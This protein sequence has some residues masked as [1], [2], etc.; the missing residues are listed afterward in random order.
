MDHFEWKM[1]LYVQNGF[2]TADVT[3]RNKIIRLKLKFSL[4][5][6]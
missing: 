1:E 2:I 3:E 5:H 4:F 6:S